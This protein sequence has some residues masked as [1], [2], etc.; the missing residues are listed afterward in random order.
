MKQI[1]PFQKYFCYRKSISKNAFTLVEV[2]VAVAILAIGL[3]GVLRAYYVL[4]NGFEISRY[5]T[6]AVCL[7]KEKVTEFE[8]KVIYEKYNVSGGYMR[9]GLENDFQWQTQINELEPQNKYLKEIKVTAFSS[10]VKPKRELS[11]ISYLGINVE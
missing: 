9:V 2:L 5:T 11:L 4:V 7:L 8:K 10:R 6:D 1:I 3:I